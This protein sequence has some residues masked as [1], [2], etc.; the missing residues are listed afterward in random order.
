M[1]TSDRMMTA[2]EVAQALHLHVNTVKRLAD[3]GEL[4]CYRVCSRGDRR[5]H[6]TDVEGY[7]ARMALLAREA[8]P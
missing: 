7:L 5:F 2:R 8:Q 6:P 4:P 3:R 1:N